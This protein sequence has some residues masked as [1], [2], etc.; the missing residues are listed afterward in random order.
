MY[1]TYLT[2]KKKLPEI[3]LVSKTCTCTCMYIS[4]KRC[5][6]VLFYLLPFIGIA[7]AKE[8]GARYRLGPELE[9]T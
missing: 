9:I 8:K 5:S 7:I 6:N 3:H 4:L 2:F 1:E